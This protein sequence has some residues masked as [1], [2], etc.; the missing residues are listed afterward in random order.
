L[1]V[2]EHRSS[3]ILKSPPRN[4]A[5]GRRFNSPPDLNRR[6]AFRR[7]MFP[8]Q[9]VFAASFPVAVRPGLFT[10]TDDTMLRHRTIVQTCRS[11]H[12]LQLLAVVVTSRRA[13]G[14]RRMQSLSLGHNQLPHRLGRSRHFAQFVWRLSVTVPSIVP[15]GHALFVL[16]MSSESGTNCDCYR[17]CIRCPVCRTD[18]SDSLRIHFS[19]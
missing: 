9:E 18:T 14:Q 16:H 15:C 19:A 13:E 5:K 12:L 4:S 7:L 3:P 6:L 8:P 1:S 17:V 10:E 2:R 11:P